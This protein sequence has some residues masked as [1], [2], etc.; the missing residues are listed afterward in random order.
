MLRFCTIPAATVVMAA[1]CA[2]SA[3]AA[4]MPYTQLDQSRLIEVSVSATSRLN[5][6]PATDGA[7]ET[8][9][10]IGSFSRSM[11]YAV[12]AQDPPPN[13][14]SGGAAAG[15]ARQEVVFGD[16]AIF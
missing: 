6:T 5:Q 13:F 11:Q 4:V 10:A 15:S 16:T 7:R 2:V 3:K 14:P 1:L 8:A 12:A 9:D